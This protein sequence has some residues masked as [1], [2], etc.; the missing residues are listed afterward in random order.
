LNGSLLDTNAALFALA[1]PRR[2][3]AKAR[4]AILAGPN[5]SSVVSF[6]EVVLKSTKG[7]LDVG[8]PR[9]WWRDALTQLAP[10]PLA[11]RPEHISGVCILPPHHRDPFDRVLIAQ[12]IVEDLSLVTADSEM[13][14]YSSAGLKIIK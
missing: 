6:W 1:A 8:D 5:L 7:K 14:S 9:T 3:S 12:A 2:L 13:A 11:L 10:T 4:V